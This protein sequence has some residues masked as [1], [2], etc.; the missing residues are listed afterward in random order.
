MGVGNISDFPR[1]EVCQ[2]W[3]GIRFLGLW[4]C[5]VLA[6]ILLIRRGFGVCCS[7]E[8]VCLVGFRRIWGVRYGHGC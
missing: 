1:N 2:V 4:I 3:L 5:R 8:G 7:W 6:L